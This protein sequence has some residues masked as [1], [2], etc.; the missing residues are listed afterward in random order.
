MVIIDK[1][2]NKVPIEGV[3]INGV[4]I[5]GNHIQISLKGDIRSVFYMGMN[6]RKVIAHKSMPFIYW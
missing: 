2:N 1:R 4:P 5:E 3:L 6:I